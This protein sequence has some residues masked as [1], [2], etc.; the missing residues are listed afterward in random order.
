MRNTT[1]SVTDSDGNEISDEVQL[2]KYNTSFLYLDDARWKDWKNKNFGERATRE[3]LRETAIDEDLID[4][5]RDGVGSIDVLLFLGGVG[6]SLYSPLGWP[7]MIYSGLNL[8]H[9][10]TLDADCGNDSGNLEPDYDYRKWDPCED[11]ALI[12]YWTEYD[13]DVP[14]GKQVNIELT[15]TVN[16]NN[17]VPNTTEN[18]AVWK[19]YINSDG[20]M[21]M[22]EDDFYL[23]SK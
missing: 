6:A 14:A 20:H 19:P 4:Q 15:Q 11:A 5:N 8:L 13:L 9:Q 10:A 17:D 22:E 18:T 12:S 21:R 23:T 3:Q 16:R 7:G 1:L 2:Q